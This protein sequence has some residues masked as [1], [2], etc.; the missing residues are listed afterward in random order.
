MANVFKIVLPQASD[1]GRLPVFWV[2]FFTEQAH[3]SLS[4][5]E[6][7]K[8]LFKSILYIKQIKICL[9]PQTTTIFHKI[10]EL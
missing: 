3:S 8:M 10:H 5:R 7:L 1:N 6:N 9:L 4:F 2:F